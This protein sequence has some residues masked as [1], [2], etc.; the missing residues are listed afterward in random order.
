MCINDICYYVNSHYNDRNT[1]SS[2]KIQSIMKEIENM[3]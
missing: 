3:V 2:S 1:E